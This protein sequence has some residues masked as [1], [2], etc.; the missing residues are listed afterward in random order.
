M[1]EYPSPP[2]LLKP[3]ILHIYTFAHNDKRAQNKVLLPIMSWTR[4]PQG[5]SDLLELET[6]KNNKGSI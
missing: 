1:K 3:I 5:F 2:P 4:P 6:E